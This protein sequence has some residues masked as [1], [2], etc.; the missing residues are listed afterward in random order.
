MTWV[1]KV[2]FSFAESPSL[3][4]VPALPL[5]V[6]SVVVLALDRGC[7]EPVLDTVLSVVEMSFEESSPARM[8]SLSRAI[9]AGEHVEMDEAALRTA[10]A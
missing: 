10:S 7:F 5:P 1:A 8:S 4:C 2:A 3:S 6:G 9:V